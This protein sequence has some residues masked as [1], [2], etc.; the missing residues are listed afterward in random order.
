VRQVVRD[1]SQLDKFKNN[2]DMAIRLYSCRA[3][4]FVTAAK[5]Q[6]KMCPAQ[7]TAIESGRPVQATGADYFSIIGI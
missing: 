6:E 2:K 1:V 4:D 3:G 7:K 5:T